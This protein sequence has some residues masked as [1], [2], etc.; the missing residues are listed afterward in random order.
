MLGHC[1]VMTDRFH[2][3]SLREQVISLNLHHSFAGLLT[4]LFFIRLL[5][6]CS[7]I[8][9]RIFLLSYFVNS[10]CSTYQDNG[11]PF[12]R[13]VP[14]SSPLSTIYLSFSPEYRRSS[15]TYLQKRD[16]WWLLVSSS[17][18]KSY[19]NCYWSPLETSPRHNQKGLLV[20]PCSITSSIMSNHVLFFQASK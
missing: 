18:K 11:F 5:A 16:F 15:W 19:Q 10:Q 12:L 9:L 3:C 6:R 7:F 4:W 13:G 20:S 14:F 2:E 8:W 17:S 1:F